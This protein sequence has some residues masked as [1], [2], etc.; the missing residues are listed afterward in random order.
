MET[1]K[2]PYDEA[3][4]ARF[5][6]KV[7]KSG[8]PDACWIWKA[9]CQKSGYGQLNITNHGQKL[10]VITAH[11]MSHIIAKNIPSLPPNVLVLH[12]CPNGDR[13]DCVNPNH[14]R[15]GTHKNN[16]EDALARNRH[17][18]GGM[19]PNHR[20]SAETVLAIRNEYAADYPRTSV[21]AMARKY[22]ISASVMLRILQKKQW[23]HV[24]GP[25]AIITLSKPNPSAARLT[26]SDVKLIR[27]INKSG[28]SQGQLAKR[29]G[30]RQCTISQII[31]RETWKHVA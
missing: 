8:G 4:L 26:E 16:V 18:V 25:D 17:V 24:G 12:S 15:A 27:T 22:K 28:T 31:R 6:S 20:L 29:F 19:S 30:V 23:K 9:S 21:K 13:R 14:L 11:R 3:T 5:W 2:H 10:T 7:D 1:P